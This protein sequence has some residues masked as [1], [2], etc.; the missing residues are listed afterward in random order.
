ML[1]RW[2]NLHKRR[3]RLQ[4]PSVDIIA[5]PISK[6]FLLGVYQNGKLTET[7][8]K[9]GFT[10]D[11]M[12]ELFDSLLKKYNI[13]RVAYAKGP[14][15]FMAIKLAYV[16]LKTLQISLDIEFLAQEAF[17]FNNN[18]PVKAVGNTYFVKKEG[19]ISIEKNQKEGEFFLPEKFRADDFEKET[20]PLYVLKAV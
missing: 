8:K 10:S 5:I 9:D 16:F 19:I 13:N 18:S 6:P 17:Y 7:I 4:K 3:M 2:W 15:S 11:V 1:L 20:L 14:G 12:P